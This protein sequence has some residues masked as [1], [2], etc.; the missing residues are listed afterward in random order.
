[1]GE[2]MPK[3]RLSVIEGC[4]HAIHLERPDDLVQVLR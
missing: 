2:R 3:A 1:M 4:G